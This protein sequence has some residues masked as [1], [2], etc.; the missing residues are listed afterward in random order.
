MQRNDAYDFV[1]FLFLGLTALTCLFTLAIMSNAVAAPGPLRV[2]TETVTVT[3]F[4]P[5]PPTATLETP[6]RTPEPPTPTSTATEP[7]TPFPTTTETPTNTP[8]I[9]LTPSLTLSP[10]PVGRI[11]NTPLPTNTETPTDEPPTNTPAP[12]FPLQLQPGTPLFRDA[13][14]YLDPECE[15]QGLAGQVTLIGGEP[16][17]GLIVRVNGTGIDQLET[18]TGLAEA[19]GSSG[20]EIQLSDT[21]S[22][23]DVTVQVFSSNGST[24]LSD[25]IDVNFSGECSQNL[26][27]VNF[28]QVVP[29]N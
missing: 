22:V 26:A 25:V 27:L 14:L 23:Q 16:A 7:F 1:T 19:Y 11:I 3:P 6:T 4:T 28:V 20:W 17:A 29:F 9:T 12:D 18:V 13:F 5:L 10:T 15:W 2:N 24:E 8:T 21:V